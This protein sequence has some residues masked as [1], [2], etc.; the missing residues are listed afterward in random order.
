MKSL[1]WGFAD[2]VTSSAYFPHSLLVEKSSRFN[3]GL[4]IYATIVLVT[5]LILLHSVG[6]LYKNLSL[7]K[8][9]HNGKCC[10][11]GVFLIFTLYRVFRSR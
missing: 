11:F 1:P 7:S 8:V 6:A 10:T 3:F 2:H 4:L 9:F 5:M